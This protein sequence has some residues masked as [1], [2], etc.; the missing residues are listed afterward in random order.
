MRVRSAFTQNAVLDGEADPAARLAGLQSGGDVGDLRAE[1]N[2][3]EAY[4]RTRYLCQEQQVIDECAH[5]L[6]GRLDPLDEPAA[7]L[8]ETVAVVLRQ[9][10]AV[11]AQRPQRRAQIMGDRIGERLQVL[12]RHHQLSSTQLDAGLELRVEHL[13]LGLGVAEVLEHV[14]ARLGCRFR[15]EA[16]GGRVL[17][18]VED[19]KLHVLELSPVLDE[20]IVGVQGGSGLIR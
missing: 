5:P 17:K 9:R 16:V 8:V 1:I 2:R 10:F 4:F 20:V 19:S 15:A 13:D 14:Q 11:P 6:G 3:S 18:D 12:V 7:G